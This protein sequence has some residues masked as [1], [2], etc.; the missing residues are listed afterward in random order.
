MRAILAV[1]LLGAGGA[2]IADVATSQLGVSPKSRAGSTALAMGSGA[3]VAVL[4]GARAIVPIM[5]GAAGGLAE[6]LIAEKY[7]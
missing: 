1:A 2:F 3:I 7:A 4:F 6:V 5:V